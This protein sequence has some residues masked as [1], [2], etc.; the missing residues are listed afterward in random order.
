MDMR[1]KATQRCSLELNS[2]GKE[3]PRT[4]K[5]LSCEASEPKCGA[6]ATVNCNRK[7]KLCRVD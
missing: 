5:E 2:I 3:Q 7:E 4:E 6:K 1:R